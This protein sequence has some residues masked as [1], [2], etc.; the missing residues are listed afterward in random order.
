MASG[1]VSWCKLWSNFRR[2]QNQACRCAL[3][4]LIMV[5]G[6]PQFRG[7]RDPY[8]PQ[9]N[10]KIVKSLFFRVFPF[11]LFINNCLLKQ[12]SCEFLQL[13][14]LH[15]FCFGV[16]CGGGSISFFSRWC[17]GCVFAQCLGM[18]IQHVAQIALMGLQMIQNLSTDCIQRCRKLRANRLQIRRRVLDQF[19]FAQNPIAHSARQ[20]YHWWKFS[21]NLQ[22]FSDTRCVAEQH[23]AAHIH[24]FQQTFEFGAFQCCFP[25]MLSVHTNFNVILMQR[26]FK[27]EILE[28]FDRVLVANQ[29]HFGRFEIFAQFFGQKNFVRMWFTFDF[30]HLKFLLLLFSAR[31]N[32]CFNLIDWLDDGIEYS[33]FIVRR[34]R[35]LDVDFPTKTFR[36]HQH[37]VR[38]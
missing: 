3:T 4:G 16:W 11:F 5:H 21:Q 34:S 38:L 7:H 24:Y 33:P 36:L 32:Y 22:N 28:P 17:R 14:P 12:C 37:I 18:R 13:N 25:H 31:L 29:Y 2:L 19:I 9:V 23:A 8:W 30:G 26:N 15:L 6:T 27:P 1:H 35:F 10:M 20:Q